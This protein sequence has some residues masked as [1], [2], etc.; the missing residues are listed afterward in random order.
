MHSIIFSR[1]NVLTFITIELLVLVLFLSPLLASIPRAEALETVLTPK[2]TRSSLGNN[3]EGGMV[4]GDINGDGSEEIVYAG[5]S[6]STPSNRRISVLN[7]ATGVVMATW[8][9]TRIGGYCQPQLEDVDSD[10]VLDILVPL[11]YQ[12]GIAVLKYYSQPP[13]LRE[14]W[15]RNVQVGTDPLG[16]CMSKPVS[17]DINGDGYTEIF[18]AT[19]D[20]E[21]PGGYDG[22]VTLFDNNGD[23]LAQTFSWRSCSGGLSLAD[24][25]N[26][27]EFELYMGDRGMY[28]GDG[29]YGKG[30]RSFWARNL[31]QRWNRPDFLCSSQAPVLADVTGDGILDVIVSNQRGGLYVIDSRNGATIRSY[32]GTPQLPVHY[33]LTVY[34]IDRDG[35]L[36]VLCNDG[37]H[38]P[39]YPPDTYVLDLTTMRVDK[40]IDLGDW[41]SKWSPLVA[42]V[43]PTHPGMEIIVGPNSSNTAKLMIFDSSYNLL[44]EVTRDSNNNML[45]AQLAYSVVQDIDNDGF[46][47]LV[48]HASV[49]RIYAFETNALAPGGIYLPGSQRIRS[50]VSFFSE[51]RT[52]AAEYIP[53]PWAQ[54]YWTAPIVSLAYP[55]DDALAVPVLTSKLS[56]TLRDQQGQPMDYT[57]TTSPNVGTGS[58]TNV[59]DGTYNVSVSGLQYYTKYTWMVRVTDG[60][61]WTER[62]YS[63]RTEF[64]PAT[65]TPPTQDKPSITWEDGK[66]WTETAFECANESTLDLDGDKVA[67]MY[68][69]YLND[70][71]VAN[72]LMPFNTRTAILAKDYSDHGY[73]GEIKGA[74]WIQNGIVGGAY[75]FDG[76]NDYIRISDGGLGYYDNKSYSSHR[77]ALGGDGTSTEITVEAWIY[78]AENDYGSRIL[79][80]MPSYE[81]GFQ[82][83]SRNRLFA[84]IW[85]NVN[86]ALYSEYYSADSDRSISR[87][88]WSHVA[89]TYRSGEG[90]RL[91]LNGDLVASVTEMRNRMTG[92]SEP[93]HGPIKRSSGEPLYLGY[94]VGYFRGSIDEVRLY[95]KC[96]TSEQVLNRYEESKDG[97]S[98]R[99]QIIPAGL[100]ASYGDV[101][102]CEVIPT[103]SFRDGDP[104]MS[105]GITL[106]RALVVRG[107]DNRIYYRVHDLS[108]DSW[109]S[110]S[111]LPSGATCDAPAAAVYRGKLFVV[112][113]GMDGYSLWFSWLNLTDNSFSGWQ[114]L[115]GATQFAPT[116]VNYG[117]QLVLVVRGLDNAVY[118][119]LYDCESVVWKNWNVLPYGYTIGSPTAVMAN[120]VLRLV[121]RGSDGYSLWHGCVNLTTSDFGGWEAISGATESKPML[122]WC[123]LRSEMLLVVRGLDNVVYYSVWNGI[124]WEGW[125]GLP[126]GATCDG[127]VATAIGDTLHII[128]RGMDGYSLWHCHIDLTTSTQSGWTALGGATQSTSTL[129]S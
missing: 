62:T 80:K 115:S 5:Y 97:L 78:L 1:R 117:S 110:W 121:A 71:Q 13:N 116:L 48:T 127:P 88:V 20:I 101:I 35:N 104:R 68:K 32:T 27:G 18:V 43:S 81:L 74:T 29:S 102:K 123:G 112:V 44:Q 120:G 21:A 42:D 2:W 105:E 70:N 75:S 122:V 28:M 111:S 73:D 126:S 108:S 52:G 6:L 26:D 3:Y 128:V 24:T 65:G 93:L 106:G 64:P 37:D 125:T 49:G 17:G 99:S 15:I 57:V 25:D 36:E 46:L 12:P 19:Q 34:D 107:L 40:I 59:H 82:T 98:S 91:Y 9:S 53:K 38:S 90:L 14:L 87:N 54:N 100:D 89:F 4:V 30:L 61:Y 31:T 55:G 114:L 118:Y 66:P 109:K 129:T 76:Y 84:G 23:Q 103:D 96:M 77:P 39:P 69:W 41:E 10:G 86:T 8:Y 83:G 124:G 72:I 92:R 94:G 60:I 67:N 50:E 45:S 7:G 51:R 22:T 58:G 119:R 85:L 95:P 113:R 11:Y 56:F 47:E 16:S 33:A 79:A 63:F